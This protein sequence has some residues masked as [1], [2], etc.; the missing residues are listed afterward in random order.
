MKPFRTAFVLLGLLTL[1]LGIAYP[2]FICG[3]GQLLFPHH[4]GGT[5]VTSGGRV[6]GSHWIAQ[7]FQKP[8]YFHPRPSSAHYNGAAS[9]GSNLGPTSAKLIAALKARAEQYR[10]EN[11][12]SEGSPIPADAVT[13]S[14]SGLD[15]H[16]GLSDARLQAPRVAKAR[17]KPVDEVLA[18]IDELAEEPFL[19]LFGS[20]RVNVLQLNLALDY[21]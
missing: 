15:P 12:L 2:L 7:D 14:G 8:H 4:A 5:I 1:L 6:V 17:S 16:I 21:S 18:L 11:G 20:Q 13:A 19:G 9:Q 10:L 3:I